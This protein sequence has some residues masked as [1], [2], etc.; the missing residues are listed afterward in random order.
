MTGEL[1][2]DDARLILKIL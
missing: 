2:V 1:V